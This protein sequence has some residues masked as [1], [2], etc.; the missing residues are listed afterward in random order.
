MKHTGK[1]LD[2]L[3]DEILEIR[4]DEHCKV[5]ANKDNYDGECDYCD[6]HNGMDEPDMFTD[7]E[8]FRLK[9]ELEAIA[10]DPNG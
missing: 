5:C 10:N 2:Q 6:F 9:C 3:A 7:Y 4:W 1:S 8:T